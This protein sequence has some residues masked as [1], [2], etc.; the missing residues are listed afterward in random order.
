M[1]IRQRRAVLQAI[2]TYMKLHGKLLNKIEYQNDNVCVIRMAQ[3]VNEFGSYE[4][5]LGFL[6]EAHPDLFKPAVPAVPKVNKVLTPESTKPAAS[7]TTK[8]LESKDK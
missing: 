4:R 6:K 8:P 7:V 5:M 3:I 1:T 2:A